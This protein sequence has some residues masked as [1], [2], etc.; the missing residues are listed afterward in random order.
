MGNENLLS[1]LLGKKEDQKGT[2]QN[3]HLKELGKKRSKKLKETVDK[4]T[5]Y[6]VYNGK[7]LFYTVKASGLYTSYIGKEKQMKDFILRCQKNGTW[8][9]QHEI[10]E[11]AHKTIAEFAAKRKG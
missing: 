4:A 3:D 11:F 7:I 2:P 6:S 8:K 9:P 5:F 1:E 10:E